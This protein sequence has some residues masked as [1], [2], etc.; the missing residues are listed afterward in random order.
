MIMVGVQF[1]KTKLEEYAWKKQEKVN[2][3]NSRRL[4]II[5][6]VRQKYAKKA[7]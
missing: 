2:K 4:L 6:Y 7:I 3:Q 1:W 5:V